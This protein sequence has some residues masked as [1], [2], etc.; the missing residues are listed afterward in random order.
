MAN[1]LK[2]EVI[3]QAIDRATRPIRAVT[4]GSVGL[5]RA[6]KD[7]RDQLKTLQAQQSDISSFRTLKSQTEQTGQALQASRDTV[8]QLSRE[9]QDHQRT[10]APLQASYNAVAAQSD[11]LSAEHKALTQQLRETRQESRA[12]NQTWQQNRLRIRE[13]GQQLGSTATPTKKLRDEYAALVAKQKD[14][15]VL[16]RALTDRQK[17][18]SQQHRESAANTRQHK[19]RVGELSAQLREAKEP[20]QGLNRAFREGVREASAL[21]RQHQDQQVQLQGLR[22]KLGAAGISTRNLSQH[23]RDLRQ[24]IEQTNQT[25][26]EQGRRMQRLT[27]QTKQLAMAR[28][29]YDK[30]QQLAGSMA[31]VGAGSAAAGAAMGMPVLSIVK[32]YMSLEDAMAGVAKQVEGARDANG[33]LTPI[34]YEMQDAIKSMAERIPMATTEIAALVEGAARMGVSGK[35]NLLAFAEVAANAATAFELPADQIGE[36][37]ARIADLY[38]IPIQNVSQLGD[39]INYLDDNAKSKGADI[40]EVLQ[41]TAGVTASVGMSYKDAAALGSTFL[42]LGSSAETAATATKAMIRELGIATEQPKRFQKGL[43]ALGLDA[44]AVQKSMARDA[45]GTIQQVLDAINKLPKENQLTVATQLFGDEFGDDAS[46]LANNIA[47]YR[48]QLEL[49]NGEAGKGSM[50]KEADIAAQLISKR[51]IMAKNRAFNLSSALGET[52]K[53]TLIELLNTLS[54]VIKRVDGWVKANPKLAG[55]ILQTVAGVAALAAGFGAVTLAMASFIGPFAMLRYGLTLI[56]IKGTSLTGVLVRLGKFALPLVWKGI[57]LIGRALLMNPIGLA[58]TAIAGAAYLIYKNWEPIKAFFLGLWE[59]IKAGFNGGFAGIAKLILDFSPLGLFYRAFAGVM[60]YFGVDMPAKFSDFGGMLLDG[61]VNGIKN[62]LGAVKDAIS[63]VGDSTVGWFKE[64]LGIHS[65][66]RVFAELG[67]FTMQGLEQGLVG[68]Q[69][70]PLGAVTA[71]AKQLAAAGAVTFGLSGPA[72]AMDN[73]PPLSPV[74]AA[75]ARAAAAPLPPVTVNVYPSAGMNE[76]QLA[77]LVGQK[78]AEAMRASQIRNRSSL[79][80]QE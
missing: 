75:G 39:A 32:D 53:P 23:E 56:G 33:N 71:M 15:L 79:S 76:Q 14:Q 45:T 51:W 13:L 29:Q 64:K 72:I 24:R 18:L 36:N 54:S 63:S 62:K 70:G 8:R 60:S 48:R 58:V 38:K 3:L 74:P 1:D 69:G 25:I 17:T 27:A 73:R 66:S 28:A 22:N 50:Q 41:R 12:A 47:E 2:M 49:A 78:V 37:L 40:I 65:P 7:S 20:L 46:N 52:L 61:L 35:D 68:G 30:S 11:K 16:V 19:E 26:T 67:G 42:T 34:Y 43:E 77:Q 4:Q 80:D 59:E 57:L 44:A 6:L 5:G 10:I 31:G 21:K 9:M 55:Q